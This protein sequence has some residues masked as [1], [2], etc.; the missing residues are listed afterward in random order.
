MTEAEWLACED[1]KVMFDFLFDERGQSRRKRG[2]RRLRMFACACVR[3]IRPLLR[4]PG[5][6]EAL[7]RA[8]CYAD[9][10]STDQEL[11]TAATAARRALAKENSSNDA[12]AWQ[13]AEAAR[14]LTVKRFDDGDRLS[15]RH[16]V[17]SAAVAWALDRVRSTPA[18]IHDVEV[19][20]RQATHA[21]W[22]RD[23]FGNPFRHATLDPDWRTTTALQLAQGIYDSRDFTS[24][25]ILADALQDAGCENAGI[26]NHCREN[27]PHV[28]GCWVVDLVLGKG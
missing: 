26:L 9:G 17:T 21:A 4:H 27:H 16:A 13:A 22:L 12:A 25:P 7:Y 14:H 3:G 23:I 11:A 20:V 8:E 19:T 6:R 1:P 24:M 5:S 10:T 2:R 15:V 18:L 28:L